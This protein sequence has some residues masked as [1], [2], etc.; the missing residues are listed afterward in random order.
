MGSLIVWLHAFVKRGL[1]MLNYG[2]QVAFLRIMKFHSFKCYPNVE[3]NWG[4]KQ[5]LWFELKST[6]LFGSFFFFCGTWQAIVID[7]GISIVF[8]RIIQQFKG[9]ISKAQVSSHHISITEI[10][11]HFCLESS[12]S[13]FHSTPLSLFVTLW[14]KFSF[15]F[16]PFFWQPCMKLYCLPV[17]LFLKTAR[18]HC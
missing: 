13:S 5:A 3:Y 1:Q 18:T 12:S 7:Y 11:L 9:L 4:N 2:I 6:F 16:G 14:C 17:L 10:L 15:P 8:T